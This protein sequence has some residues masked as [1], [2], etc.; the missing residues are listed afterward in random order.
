MQEPGQAENTLVSADQADQTG[1][2][3]QKSA[4]ATQESPSDEQQEGGP[5]DQADQADQPPS[6]TD[7]EA[8]AKTAQPTVAEL[9]FSSHVEERG[10][11]WFAIGVV[12]VLAGLFAFSV[13]LSPQPPASLTPV[14][15]L[16]ATGCGL[17]VTALRKLRTIR[18]P[19]LLEAALG[20]FGLAVLQFIAAITYPDVFKIISTVEGQRVGFLSTWGL[21]AC[22]SI[23]FSIAGATLG[24]PAFAPLRPLPTKAESVT[25]SI[26][27]AKTEEEES[28]VVEE[29]SSEEQ[30]DTKTTEERPEVEESTTVTEERPEAE[31]STTVT[32]ERPEVEESTTTAE[33]QSDEEGEQPGEK[34]D[35]SS[36]SSET[37]QEEQV[38]EPATAA[39]APRSLVSYLI[40]VLLLG[41]A[42][43]VVGYV[44]SAAFDL[45]LN[46]NHFFP[47]PF[48][49]LRLLSTMLPW[50]VPIPINLSGSRTQFIIF[51]LWRIPLFFGN[52][53]LFDIQAL[54][55]FVFNGA[56]LGML[57][58]IMHGKD[59]GTPGQLVPLS[60][61]TYLL[62]EAVL[63]LAL[64]LPADLWIAQ[65]VQGLLQ[66]QDI[67]API[68]ALHLL[69]QRT[70]ILNLISGPLMCMGIGAAIRWLRRKL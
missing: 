1:Q 45:M 17:L 24:H 31:D 2:A 23:I 8:T 44:F 25:E 28:T 13:R 59:S 41:L 70:F 12:L 34:A 14:A 49:T 56:A 65:G 21:V 52:P 43:T 64:V 40:T 6:E 39:T 42:P 20:G 15:V 18:R 35:E 38:T 47:G 36:E 61:R 32:E 53:T 60:W 37:Y 68:P 5:T 50:Q 22:F 19:G 4:D 55:P 9:P 11:D 62:L 54:E 66:I 26:P 58:L 30:E 3:G 16:S 7:E 51:L 10:F 69:D 29:Q 57:L 46:V 33:K 63:G 67:I 27:E 48:P